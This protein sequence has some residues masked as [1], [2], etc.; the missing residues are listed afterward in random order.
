MRRFY[1]SA[2]DT[3]GQLYR[4]NVQSSKTV[5]LQRYTSIDIPESMLAARQFDCFAEGRS[6]ER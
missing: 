2:S 4:V 5:I 6:Y 3:R 1:P